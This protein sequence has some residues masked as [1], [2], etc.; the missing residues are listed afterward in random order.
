MPDK[1][2]WK[3]TAQA[4]LD[5]ASQ[6][7]KG[8]FNNIAPKKGDSAL[9]VDT[10]QYIDK[11]VE[12]QFYLD[13][14]IKVGYGLSQLNENADLSVLSEF[15]SAVYNASLPLLSQ[16]EHVDSAHIDSIENLSGIL[17]NMESL[18][19]FLPDLPLE[20]SGFGDPQTRT[21]ALRMVLDRDHLTPQ[22]CL[23]REF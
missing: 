21:E 9:R 19:E 22:A 10:K 6:I 4:E 14:L 13:T 20:S 18:D 15:L 11:I 8:Y 23:Y 17:K 2:G 5:Y 7:L 3:T 16:V 1:A 12:L